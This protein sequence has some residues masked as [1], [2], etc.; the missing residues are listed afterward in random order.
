MYRVLNRQRTGCCFFIYKILCSCCLDKDDYWIFERAPEPSDINWENMGLTCMD[1]CV[2]QLVSIVST[3]IMLAGSFLAI[4]FI[5][6]YGKEMMQEQLAALNEQD[7]E[8][9]DTAEFDAMKL[10]N[11]NLSYVT[12]VIVAI[13]NSLMPIIMRQFSLWEK[14]ETKTDLSLTLSF[15]LSLLKF[16]NTSVIFAAVHNKA[17]DWFKS[18]NLVNDVFIVLIFA[19]IAPLFNLVTF[20]TMIIIQRCKITCCASEKLT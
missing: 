13:I 4:Y 15:K 5:K 7:S 14:L 18:G 6:M 3:L 20:L 8:L 17:D 12:A 2:R 19:M 10:L 16:L 11:E 1:A 9:A